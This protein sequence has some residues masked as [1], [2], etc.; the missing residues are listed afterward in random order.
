MFLNCHVTMG[1]EGIAR[2]LMYPPAAETAALPPPA[3][4]WYK[5]GER[6]Q[7]RLRRTDSATFDHVRRGGL[8]LRERLAEST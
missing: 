4:E 8:L 2:S 6:E 3:W 7:R 1:C 5:P